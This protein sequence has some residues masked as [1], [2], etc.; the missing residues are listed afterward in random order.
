MIFGKG[1]GWISAFAINFL[2]E[3]PSLENPAPLEAQRNSRRILVLS[4]VTFFNYGIILL[5]NAM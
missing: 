1:S 2:T 4:A 3:A 5:L